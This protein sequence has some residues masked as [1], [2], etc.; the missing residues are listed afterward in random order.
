VAVV[1]A[2]SMRRPTE[3]GHAGAAVSQASEDRGHGVDG[4]GSSILLT[5][6]L[7]LPT[8][9]RCT[10]RGGCSSSPLL[11]GLQ[12]RQQ[13]A[14]CS[15][16]ASGAP[17]THRS[18]P[19]SQRRSWS[20]ARGR[21]GR[22]KSSP[23]VAAACRVVEPIA[24]VDR[25]ERGLPP[26]HRWSRC[27][28][29]GGCSS[30][31]QRL[32]RRGR[33]WSWWAQRRGATTRRRCWGIESPLQSASCSAPLGERVLALVATARR[34]LEPTAAAACSRRESG[35]SLAHHYCWTWY[36]VV[37]VRPRVTAAWARSHHCAARTLCRL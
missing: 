33:S 15:R 18:E 22:M 13:A 4:G 20:R 1:G 6:Q 30:S 32:T 19:S 14:A 28:P 3:R 31:P 17:Q 35:S 29:R 23:L 24:V 34:A 9:H 10:P 16:R 7:I 27:I 26:A 2:T 11:G 36:A 12:S 25:G 21:G 37:V 5:A 8:L